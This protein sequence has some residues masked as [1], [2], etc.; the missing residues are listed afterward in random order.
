MFKEKDLTVLAM[1]KLKFWAWSPEESLL[2]KG[3][4]LTLMQKSKYR[5]WTQW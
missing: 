1:A 5:H 2:F 4:A 3:P